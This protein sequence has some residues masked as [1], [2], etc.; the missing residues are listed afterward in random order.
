MICAKCGGDSSDTDYCSSCGAKMGGAPSGLSAVQTSAPS[1][2]RVSASPDGVGNLCP[3]CGTPRREGAK[4]CEVCRYNFETGASGVGAVIVPAPAPDPVVPAAQFVPTVAA[5]APVPAAADTGLTSVPPDPALPASWEIVAHVDPTLY[6]DR[7]PSVP[8]PLDEPDRVFPL[9]FAENLIG[10]RS[11]KKDIHPEIPLA[12]P[13]VSHRHAKLLRSPDGSF[14]LLDVG[15]TNG[16]H[17]NGVE[18]KPG[19]RT[20]LQAGDEIVLGCW[21]RITLR[22]K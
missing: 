15:S 19:V 3:D 14:A 6:V 16:T 20:P 2:T 5:P 7:D 1:N 9:D 18:V 21:T 12:D 4:F 8:C 17:L 11:D 22:S 13:G 10:R